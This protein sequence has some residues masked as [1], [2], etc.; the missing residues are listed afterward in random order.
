MTTTASIG[1]VARAAVGAAALWAFALPTVLHGH[2]V[3][4]SESRI[5]VHG[6]SVAATL[7]VNLQDFHALPDVDRNHDGVV[8]YDEMDAAIQQVYAAVAG[9]FAVH[10]GT[11][12][13]AV[14]V[15]R[16]RV[17]NDTLLD[18]EM[19]YTFDTDVDAL[20]IESS[21]DKVTQANHRHWLRLIAGGVAQDAVLDAATPA[22]VFDTGR[23]ATLESA[24]RFIRSGFATFWIRYVQLAFFIG[25]LVG[26][27][28]ARAL[29][30]SAGVFVLAHNLA[31]LLSVGASPL[32]AS[33]VDGLA[34]LSVFY[35][36]ME[37][38]LGRLPWRAAATAAF[39]AIHGVGMAS[40]LRDLQ[41]PHEALA[42]PALSFVAGADI[43]AAIVF[44]GVSMLVLYRPRVLQLMH[45]R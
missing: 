24:A 43:A 3:S 18:L 7:T 8:S 33:A 17:H 6:R 38:R 10:A 30:G 23:R 26:E 32:P 35:V 15:E 20:Q 11:G 5:T 29:F 14:S 22:A 1:A 41:L 39:A 27:P 31:L 42:V 25:L 13:P 40:G 12:L 36:L 4:Q 44:S 9:H 37:M 28:N 21:L 2:D 45:S 16:Y 34:V 19:S